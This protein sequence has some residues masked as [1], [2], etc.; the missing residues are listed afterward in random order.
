[1]LSMIFVSLSTM[2]I[3]QE[4]GIFDKKDGMGLHSNVQKNK[5]IDN[6]R[7]IQK[8]TILLQFPV[9]SL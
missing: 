8:K 2:I 7:L 5:T 1:M 3:L 6:Q 9:H 4:W